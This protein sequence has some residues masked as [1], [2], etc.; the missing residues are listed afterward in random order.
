MPIENSIDYD[1]FTPRIAVVGVGGQGSNLVTRLF[2]SGIK[3][4]DTIA[5]N[6]DLSHLNITRAHKKLLLGKEITNG[7]GA[8]G[9][10][11][12]AAKCADASRT[13]IEKALEGYDLVFIA[14]GMG[15]GT[16]T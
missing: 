15:G 9:F 8:G 3:S 14:A 13:E 10:P 11:E 7:L 5:M 1:A 6:T 16:G 12:V 2:N 4:A